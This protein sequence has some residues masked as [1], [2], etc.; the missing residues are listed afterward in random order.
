MSDGP[1]SGD[2]SVPPT[3]IQ[4]VPTHYEVLGIPPG[5]DDAA[6]Q[7]GYRDRLAQ[8]A[9]AGPSGGALPSAEQVEEARNVLL[10]PFTRVSYDSKH[11]GADSAYAWSRD[12]EAYHGKSWARPNDYQKVVI[13][14]TVLIL[15]TTLVIGAFLAI[16][17]RFS[18]TAALVLVAVTVL[19]VLLWVIYNYWRRFTE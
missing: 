18:V 1:T 19:P 15:L 14:G 4:G 12:N 10:S 6:I 11:F 5:A 7:Q 16:A 13:S 9:R 2:P 3:E 8:L 17:E